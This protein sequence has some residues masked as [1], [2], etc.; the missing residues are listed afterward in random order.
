MRSARF[1]TTDGLVLDVVD[2]AVKEGVVVFPGALTAGEILAAWKAGSDFVKVVP[3][4]AVGGEKY[5][6]ALKDPFPQ[7]PLIAAGGVNQQTAA[8]F[9]LAGAIGLGIGTDLIPWESIAL[10]QSGR[11][12]EL[13]PEDFCGSWRPVA[14]KLQLEKR[15]TIH[16]KRKEGT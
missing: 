2:F 12:G 4:S 9:I 13:A 11:I 10:R 5:I 8:G 6:K 14:R 7:I 3:C 1:L 15:W 16:A